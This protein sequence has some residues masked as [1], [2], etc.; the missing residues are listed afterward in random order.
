MSDLISLSPIMNLIEIFF[1]YYAPV[2]TDLK[3]QL[4][5]SHRATPQLLKLI[6][7]L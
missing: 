6:D 2:A 7:P 5:K 1:H 3:I 4:L